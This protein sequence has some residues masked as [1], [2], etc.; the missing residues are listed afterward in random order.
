LT[1]GDTVAGSIPLLIEIVPAAGGA[2]VYTLNR[3]HYL[4][5]GASVN[6]T[7]SFDFGVTGAFIARI[8]GAKLSGGT[9]SMPVKVLTLDEVT[10][11]V[12][13][14]PTSGGVVPVQVH[15][16]NSGY[17]DFAG[18]LVIEAGG[19]RHEEPLQVLSEAA[20]DQAYAFDA[21]GLAGGSQEVIAYIYD[22][23]GNI[24][25]QNVLTVAVANA[26]SR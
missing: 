17:S 11:S 12:A 4:E 16:A 15:V 21:N 9:V 5:P 2:P 13:V 24:L 6:D 8:S 25:S 23:A 7:F 20:L 26:T 1:N 3:S 18:T 22:A 14:Q 10:T 19:L